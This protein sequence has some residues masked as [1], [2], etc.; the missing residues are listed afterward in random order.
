MSKSEES[1]LELKEALR[2]LPLETVKAREITQAISQYVHDVCEEYQRDMYDYVQS[3]LAQH[4][5]T[6]EHN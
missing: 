6:N 1:Y 3:Q 5:E 4:R 2:E